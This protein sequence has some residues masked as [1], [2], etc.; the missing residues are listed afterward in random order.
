[1]SLITTAYTR[2]KLLEHVLEGTAEG[3]ASV[4]QAG[5]EQEKAKQREKAAAGATHVPERPNVQSVTLA[6]R[7][8]SSTDLA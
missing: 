5:E 3:F 2:K 6:R 4:L 1:M 8:L 7:R